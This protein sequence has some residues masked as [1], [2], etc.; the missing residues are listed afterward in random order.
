MEDD[1]DNV[2]SSTLEAP[3]YTGSNSTTM[4]QPNRAFTQ[5]PLY[6]LNAQRNQANQAPSP[7]PSTLNIM[8]SSMGFKTVVDECI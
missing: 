7:P 3:M 2:L 8:E 6:N 1:L 5:Q 4:A